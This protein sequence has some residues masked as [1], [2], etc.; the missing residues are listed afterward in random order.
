MEEIDEI[1]ITSHFK[2]FSLITDKLE[3]RTAK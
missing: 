1:I 3:N 2:I